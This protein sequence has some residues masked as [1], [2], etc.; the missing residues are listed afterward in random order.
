MDKKQLLTILITVATTVIFR[1]FFVWFISLFK[2]SKAIK[3]LKDYC[4]KILTKNVLSVA[5]NVLLLVFVVG[6][7]IYHAR[8][9]SPLTR[10]EVLT[11]ILLSIAACAQLVMLAFILGRIFSE[12]SWSKRDKDP[13]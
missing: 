1:E 7:L 3:T 6:F 8:S 2:D 12:R 5:W 11:M 4:A 10:G 9:S 13:A